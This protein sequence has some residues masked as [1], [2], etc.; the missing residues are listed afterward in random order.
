MKS[1]WCLGVA[2]LASVSAEVNGDPVWQQVPNGHRW[3]DS[4]DWPCSGDYQVRGVADDFTLETEYVAAIGWWG[5]P[6]PELHASLDGFLVTVSERAA[7]GSPG[8]EVY[9][10][11]LQPLEAPYDDATYYYAT[12]AG[13]MDLEPGVAYMLSIRG[14]GCWPV[15]WGWATSFGNG[16]PALYRHRD[17]DWR[18][19]PPQYQPSFVLFDR[20]QDTP[21][22]SATW[23]R[24]KDLYQ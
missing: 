16:S 1:W 12:L 20:R 21:V 3:V 22:R 19:L 17:G 18:A 10:E 8:L 14:Q 2:A 5:R 15:S 7:D 13:Y 4:W 11:H 9:S 6:Y 23:G 24:V